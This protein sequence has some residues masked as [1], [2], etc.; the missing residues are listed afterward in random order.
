MVALLESWFRDLA[1][2]FCRGRRLVAELPDAHEGDSSDRAAD[3][4]DLESGNALVQE[5]RRE[6]DRDDREEGEERE[7]N[8]GIATVERQIQEHEAECPEQSS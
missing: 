5:N 3:A 7:N 4:S 1:S 8:T 6:K 2:R